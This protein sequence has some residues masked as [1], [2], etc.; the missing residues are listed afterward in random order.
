MA[1]MVVE[2]LSHMF[3]LGDGP[4]IIGRPLGHHRVETT[5]RYAHIARDSMRKSVKRIAVSIADDILLEVL[6]CSLF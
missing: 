4:P 1:N 5:A 3:A 6:S 2:T